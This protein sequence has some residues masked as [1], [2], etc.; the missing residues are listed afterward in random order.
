M[1][2]H[3]L[4]KKLL[5]M[6][7]CEVTVREYEGGVN[8]IDSISEPA[9]LALNVNSAWYYGKHDYTDRDESYDHCK[10]IQAIH[11]D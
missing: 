4:A 11:L 1:T 3:E 8:I 6:P 5:E 9:E 10:K 7:D 2:S